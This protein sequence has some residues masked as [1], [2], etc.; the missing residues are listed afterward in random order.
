[1]VGGTFMYNRVYQVPCLTYPTISQAQIEKR[2]SSIHPELIPEYYTE[3]EENLLNSRKPINYRTAS[4]A[5]S[6][7]QSDPKQ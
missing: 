3:S 6:D 4:W 2:S 1:L 7:S 5:S